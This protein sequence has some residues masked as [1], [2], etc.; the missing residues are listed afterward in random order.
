MPHRL[1]VF[2][3]SSSAPRKLFHRVVKMH[4]KPQRTELKKTK[5]KKKTKSISDGRRKPNRIESKKT[6][7][8]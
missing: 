7:S 8:T 1:Q 5:K 4:S 6:V 2:Y 3:K